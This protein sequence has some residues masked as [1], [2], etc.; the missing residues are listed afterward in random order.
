MAYSG[1]ILYCVFLF[2]AATGQVSQELQ[3]YLNV[4]HFTTP[5]VFNA[6]DRGVPLG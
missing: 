5:F 1:L 6:T 4:T 2:C 3:R